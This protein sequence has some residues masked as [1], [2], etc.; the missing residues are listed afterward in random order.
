[1]LEILSVSSHTNIIK[2]IMVKTMLSGKKDGN[3]C[4]SMFSSPL[5]LPKALH[6]SAEHRYS[7]FAVL[8]ETFPLRSQCYSAVKWLYKLDLHCT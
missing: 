6:L 1:M 7:A 2:E 5:H 3:H 8:Q 4:V